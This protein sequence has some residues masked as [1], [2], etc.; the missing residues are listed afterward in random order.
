[1]EIRTELSESLIATVW[2]LKRID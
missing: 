1:V 2:L